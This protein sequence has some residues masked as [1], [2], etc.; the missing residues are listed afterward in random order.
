MVSV[1]WQR[2]GKLTAVAVEGDPAA[3]I[4]PVVNHADGVAEVGALSKEPF[5][6]LAGT[7]RGT[8]VSRSDDSVLIDSKRPAAIYDRPDSA[9]MLSSSG[10]D[11][12]GGLTSR[13]KEAKA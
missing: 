11:S 10:T 3:R 12:F 2:D 1:D 6:W 7:I 9:L 8:R 5:T 4:F 13:F